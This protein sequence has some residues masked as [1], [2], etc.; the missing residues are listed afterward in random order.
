MQHVFLLFGDQVA[1]VLL[2]WGV[3]GGDTTSCLS[4]KFLNQFRFLGEVSETF[5]ELLGEEWFVIDEA[6]ALTSESGA[7]DVLDFEL[8]G[9]R[10]DGG[11]ADVE[12]RPH[13][14]IIITITAKPYQFCFCTF[15]I[16]VLIDID[17]IAVW[18]KGL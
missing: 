13:K 4:F 8:D 6:V 14:I 17:A 2:C 7:F 5:N 16:L 15:R 3:W 1:I 18:I 10:G 9:S 11:D 12:V